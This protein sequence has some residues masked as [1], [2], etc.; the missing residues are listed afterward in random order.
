MLAA[1]AAAIDQN[2]SNFPLVLGIFTAL[3]AID[4]VGLILGKKYPRLDMENSLTVG[5]PFDRY[6]ATAALAHTTKLVTSK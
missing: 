5:Y 4:P 6:L 2:L 3:D 1:G